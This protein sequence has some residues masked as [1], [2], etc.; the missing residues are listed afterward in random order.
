VTIINKISKEFYD[1][2]VEGAM[3]KLHDVV[4]RVERSRE[5]LVEGEDCYTIAIDQSIIADIVPRIARFRVGN[6][7]FEEY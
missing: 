1:G 4:I 2:W 3:K 5:G 7:G 6:R